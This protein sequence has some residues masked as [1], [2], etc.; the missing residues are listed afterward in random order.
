MET[1]HMG[2]EATPPPR[3]L[4]VSNDEAIELCRQWMVY[5]GA[6]DSVVA[7]GDS[8]RACDLYSSRFLGWV[9]T[10]GGN[11]NVELVEHAAQVATSDGRRALVFVP[12]GVYPDA[13]DRAD[14]LGIALLR[15]DP[16]G[17]D[18]DGA[19]LAGRQLRG[20]GL[21]AN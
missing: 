13:Q 18:L 7:S 5:L 21:A 11:L 4:G 3:P 14:V 12:G 20:S 10:R 17:G 6:T 15:F 8:R 1:W 19:N 2:T 9:D 16:Y